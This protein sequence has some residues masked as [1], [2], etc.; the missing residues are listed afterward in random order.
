MV[1]L[2][3]KFIH[4]IQLKTPQNASCDSCHGHP[5]LF[6]NEADVEPTLREANQGVIVPKTPE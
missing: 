5:E 4:N 6:L 3:I 1:N 2:K